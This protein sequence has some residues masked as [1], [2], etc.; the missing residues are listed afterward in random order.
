MEALNAKIEDLAGSI[1]TDEADLKAA[2]EI[3]VKEQA[4]FAAEESELT[5]VIGMLERA[6]NI[7]QRE[8]AKGGASMM[9][10]KNTNN[11]ADALRV[12]VQAAAFSS[13]DASR[14]TA[15][16]QS[17][18]KDT[19]NEDDADV[20]APDA[21]V[22]EGHGGGIIATLNGLLEKANAQLD[23]A[24]STETANKQNYEMHHS[25]QKP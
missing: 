12:L 2:G 24:R 15:L 1:Q 3:R 9:Q 10:L 11:I 23:S 14:L 5:Q 17:S 25:M 6:S 18:Q 4:D 21:A 8:M 20:G 7:L 19:T 13:A 16:L 22:Y